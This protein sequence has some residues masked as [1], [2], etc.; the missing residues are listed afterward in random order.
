MRTGPAIRGEPDRNEPR[1]C[2][3]S[4]G[5]S[6]QTLNMRIQH[7]ME[8]QQKM[9][10][11]TMLTQLANGF[12]SFV[13]LFKLARQCLGKGP[14]IRCE[15]DKNEPNRCPLPHGICKQTRNL[16]WNTSINCDRFASVTNSQ[17][18][19]CLSTCAFHLAWQCLGKSPAIR[20]EP[21]GNE[22]MVCQLSQGICKQT[23]SLRIQH[24]S[25]HQPKL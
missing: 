4:R 25:V 20:G 10:F 13:L 7:N 8:H 3:L 23:L 14:A 11:R 16:R 17:T 1:V 12:V 24:K 6:K 18:A 2:Q 19:V 15:P 9:L 22:P 5:V 21:V